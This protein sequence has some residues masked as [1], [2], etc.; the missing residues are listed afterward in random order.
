M[1][2]RPDRQA[3]F[4]S[5]MDAQ[6][7]KQRKVWFDCLPSVMIE[8][9]RAINL[10]KESLIEAG[11]MEKMTNFE[12]RTLTKL[13]PMYAEISKI[14]TSPPFDYDAERR[15]RELVGSMISQINGW[16]RSSKIAVGLKQEMDPRYTGKAAIAAKYELLISNNFD[17]TVNRGWSN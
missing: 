16:F 7:V 12:T 1:Y 2:N 8:M 4:E 3:K 9:A 15:S 17:V 13:R 6:I 10:V 14:R 5:F 11:G